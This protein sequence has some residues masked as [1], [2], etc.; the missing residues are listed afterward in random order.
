MAPQT[1]QPGVIE[2]ELSRTMGASTNAPWAETPQQRR[3]HFVHCN[4]TIAATANMA[5]D[6]H[7]NIVRKTGHS[8]NGMQHAI[9]CEYLLIDVEGG[10]LPI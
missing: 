8:N 7:L 6:A 3:L 2:S 1:P 9:G 10:Q 4:A 5:Q